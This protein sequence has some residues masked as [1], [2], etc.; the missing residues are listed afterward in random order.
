MGN[1]RRCFSGCFLVS[2][3]LLLSPASLWAEGWFSQAVEGFTLGEIFQ[4]ANLLLVVLGGVFGGGPAGIW[5]VKA[6]AVNRQA[7]ALYKALPEDDAKLLDR[8]IQAR[9]KELAQAMTKGLNLTDQQKEL[10]LLAI[11]QLKK[12]P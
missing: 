5:L 8:A 12:Q 4:G 7:I 3:I 9:Q 1:F 10:A 6:L 2:L 11:R